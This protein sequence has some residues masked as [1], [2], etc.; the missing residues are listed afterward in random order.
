M[1]VEYERELRHT[2]MSVEVEKEYSEDYQMR[3]IQN[4][5]ISGL[6]IMHG[7]GVDEK[8]RYRYEITGKI[9]MKVLGE[10]EG[11]GS[12]EM[13]DFMRQ[14]VQVLGELGDYMLNIHC[15]LLDP[16]YI[17]WQDGKYYF[18]YCPA[19]EKNLW[20]EFHVLTEYFV[21]ETDYEDKEAIYFA[22]ELHKSSMEE[23][24][25]IE[26]VLEQIIERKEEELNRVKKKE[27]SY[28]LEEDK[29]LDNWM[30]EQNFKGEVVRERMGV[31]QYVS[32]KL[33]KG[34]E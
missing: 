24:Y 25:N 12:A 6:L 30:D 8:S 33:R 7:Q 14:F 4:N 9:S 2:W 27:I 18:C 1:K 17:Y 23:N 34:L 19:L 10:R 21:R 3:M 31:W 13:E 15:L 22:Y 26:N 16:E 29:I 20:E 28:E 32:R 11:W 5:H